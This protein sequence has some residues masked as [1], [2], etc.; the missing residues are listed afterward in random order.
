MELSLFPLE[1]FRENQLMVA[2]EVVIGESRID[3]EAVDW[4]SEL[5]M[6]PIG[7]V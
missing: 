1:V 2:L 7:G 3:L 5:E 6:R 4:G